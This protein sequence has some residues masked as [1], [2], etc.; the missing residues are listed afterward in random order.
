M[1]DTK[2]YAKR[3]LKAFFKFLWVLLGILLKL[4]LAACYIVLRL[5]EIG[6]CHINKGT[7]LVLMGKVQKR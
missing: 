1:S 3:F 2:K 6:L 4:C 7:E 5:L